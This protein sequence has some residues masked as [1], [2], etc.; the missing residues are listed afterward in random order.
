MRFALADGGTEP[1]GNRIIVLPENP[2]R[3]ELRDPHSGFI[4]YV[5]KGSIA[6][7]AA[8]MAGGDGKTIACTIC[9]GPELK[10]LGEVPGIAGRPATYIFRQLND[11]KTGNRS[12]PRVELMKQAVAKL[13]QDDMIALAAYLGSLDPLMAE[14]K[15]LGDL[16]DRDRDHLQARDH[17]SRRR[18]RAARIHLRRSSTP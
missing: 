4:D 10:G 18:G 17:R 16:I 8:L 3:A 7:G 1:I 2:E 11:I 14:F 12:G 6:K 15:N 9:H 5:P 13:T